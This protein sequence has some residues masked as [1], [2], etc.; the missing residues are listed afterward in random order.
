MEPIVHQLEP[1]PREI[2]V[3]NQLTDV[4]VTVKIGNAQEGGNFV[5]VDG[6][7]LVKGDFSNPKLLGKAADLKDKEMKFETNVLDVN[8]FSNQCVITTTFTNTNQK[9]LFKQIDDGAAPKN[10]IASFQGVYVIKILSVLLFILCFSFSEVHSQ[11][12]KSEFSSLET[13]ASPG[14]ILFDQTPSAIEKPATP[15][16]LGFSV[17]SLQQ[18]GGA[19]EVAPYWL[20]VHPDL[21]A[22]VFNKLL[23][24]IVEHF[25]ISIASV[26]ADSVQN[27]AVGFRT[28]LLQVYDPNHLS[29]LDTIKKNIRSELSNPLSQ[30]NFKKIEELRQ[31]YVDVASRPTLHIDLAGAVGGTSVSKS[32]K[33][34]EY[35]RWSTWLS[36]NYRPKGDDFYF[37]V[38]SRYR[39]NESLT[40]STD[41]DVV[42]LGSRFNYDIGNFALSLEYLQRFDLTNDDSQDYRL[43]VI[44]SY[45]ITNNLSITSSFG[46]NFEEVD[47]VI[48]LAGINFGLSKSAVKAF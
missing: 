47:N 41:T 7:E 4:F 34:I 2:A 18:N 11:T 45:K 43:A 36:F 19:I 25:S 8:S 20:K 22:D 15:Q 40:T 21:T 13:P 27:F 3:D 9:V 16:G 5:S 44:G 6:T 35:N 38:L 31:K 29:K 17:L 33:D 23:F 39:N 30:L 46:K 37:T 26:E 24:P 12:D 42:D 48:A 32:Y 1:N 10:G 28:R 14:F